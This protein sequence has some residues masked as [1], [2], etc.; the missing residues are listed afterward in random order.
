MLRPGR[1]NRV[2]S[3][4][5]LHDATL[6]PRRPQMSV[7]VTQGFPIA[8]VWLWQGVSR[9]SM[10]NSELQICCM[11]RGNGLPMVLMFGTKL[12]V[13]LLFVRGA[14]VLA[15]VPMCTR[16]CDFAQQEAFSSFPDL[17]SAANTRVSAASRWRFTSYIISFLFPRILESAGASGG[18]TSGAI[19]TSSPTRIVQLLWWAGFPD[20]GGGFAGHIKDGEKVAVCGGLLGFSPPVLVVALLLTKFA[21]REKLFSGDAFVPHARRRGIFRRLLVHVLDGDQVPAFALEFRVRR[22]Q[23]RRRAWLFG[24]AVANY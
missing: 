7:A 18:V 10:K 3:P 12:L 6:C 20:G 2:L 8:A 11:V 5:V 16:P 19:L 22:G 4:L 24:D 15:T 17:V 14:A 9:R 21:P 13:I 1:T 23:H